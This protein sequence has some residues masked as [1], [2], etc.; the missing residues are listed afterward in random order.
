MLQRRAGGTIVELNNVLVVESGHTNGAPL[1]MLFARAL[2]FVAR[3]YT[4][5]EGKI[6]T[7]NTRVKID[8]KS[9]RCQE[10]GQERRAEREMF[11]KTRKSTHK[12]D[13]V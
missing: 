4:H 1:G 12:S 2:E 8:V 9:V 10:R 3:E 7:S 11:V 6:S 5:R 13:N